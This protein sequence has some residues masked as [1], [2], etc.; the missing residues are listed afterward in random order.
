MTKVS[1]RTTLFN[2]FCLM[3]L[4]TTPVFLAACGGGGG[5]GSSD[6]SASTTV[7]QAVDP[8]IVGAVFQEIAE[9]GQTLL[10]RS[11]TTT[12]DQG[13]FSFPKEVTAGSTIEMKAGSK[14]MHLNSAY[15]GML[16]YKVP[17]DGPSDAVV[18]P[19]TT[20]EA[21]GFTKE[22]IISMMADAGLSGLTTA[23][24]NFDPMFNLKGQSSGVTAADM[25]PLQANMAINAMLETVGENLDPA[26]MNDQDHK[27]L[28]QDIVGATVDTMNP[29]LFSQM[30]TDV[31]NQLGVTVIMDDM[32]YAAVNSQNLMVGR[33]QDAI[34]ASGLPLNSTVLSNA[35]AD[36]L[37]QTNTWMSSQASMRGG[38]NNGGGGNMGNMAGKSLYDNDCAGCHK[39]GTYDATGFAPDLLGNGSMVA[40]KINGG[41]NGI[42]LTSAELTD[43]AAWIDNPTQSNTGS[44]SGTG[45]T[46][47][48]T[49]T[50]G[51]TV[52]GQTVYDDNCATCH[53]LGT[54][55]TV[56]MGTTPDLSGK[57]NLVDAKLTAGHNN[58]S[59][60]AD[61]EAALI[62]FIDSQTT[63][64]TTT[65]PTTTD[66]ATLYAQECQTCHQ[67]LASTTI[68]NRTVA[69]I[70]AAIANNTGNMG[71]ISLTT[72]EIQSIVDVLPAAT[73][74]PTTTDGA[75]LYSQ[76]CQTCH[77]ALAST[78]IVSRSVSTIESAIA[79]DTGGMGTINLT[80]AQLQAIVDV[81]PVATTPGTG[82]GTTTPADGASLYNTYCAGCHQV[83][84]FD[85]TGTAPDLA[86]KGSLIANKL[87]TGHNGLSLATTDIDTLAAWLDTFTAAGGTPTPTDCTS[88]HSQPPDGTVAPNEAGAHAVH[89]ALANIDSCD[90]CHLGASH[91]GTVDLAFPANYDA[92]SGTA[93]G[94]S[95]NTCSNISCHGGKD[96]PNWYTGQISVD[97]ECTACHASGTSQYNS[98]N[99]GDHRRHSSYACT[100][101]HNTT[102]LATQHFSNL[103]TTTFEGAASATIG[104]GS[105]RI[106]SYDPSTRRCVGCHGSATW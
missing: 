80:T 79:A 84:T 17:A 105:T 40:G 34:A 12:D 103:S 82:G 95:D 57:S 87:G 30:A 32:I 46:N 71:T 10:Q 72:A 28:L 5:G 65:P 100:V 27:Q 33:M 45:T 50:G 69:A 31:G 13:H 96:T 52:N 73:T 42:S 89:M 94:Y 21:N 86:G 22:E 53:L 43:L 88:C 37:A 76:N 97:S 11:S 24:F 68:N 58:I 44:G 63:T 74:P 49:G 70:E 2:L 7:F 60:T 4:A 91:N 56:G 54:Y 83:N 6:G 23:D 9:D 90:T 77:Q 1:L 38:S 19:M 29:T 64:G 47:P 85:S 36:C 41:H 26:T 61:E 35:V 48:G 78:N 104:G 14:G 8:Y 3:V 55:D 92:K 99:S 39:L 81:L 18:S 59:L 101:C 93:V 66:G 20:L 16:R 102:K 62:A 15:E 25:L 75:T 98:Y 51:T 67:L 106:S